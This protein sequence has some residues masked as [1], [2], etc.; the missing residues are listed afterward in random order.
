MSE[1]RQD[2]LTNVGYCPLC[3]DPLDGLTI[4][5]RGVCDLHGW[6]WAEW[7]A[8]ERTAFQIWRSALPPAVS[9]DDERND[10]P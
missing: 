2:D 1:Y 4:S 7:H 10:A 3:G 6:Q 9:D 8:H 5:G